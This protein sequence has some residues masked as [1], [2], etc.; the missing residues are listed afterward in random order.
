MR[1]VSPG[2]ARAGRRESPAS[3]RD[4]TVQGAEG[5]PREWKEVWVMRSGDSE[6]RASTA[7]RSRRLTCE[8]RARRGVKTLNPISRV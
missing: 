2:E 3:R 1:G 8:E 7:R 4:R 6:A 5:A